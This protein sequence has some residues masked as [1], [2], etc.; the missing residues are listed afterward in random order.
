MTDWRLHLDLKDLWDED[1]GKEPQFIDWPLRGKQ[2][3]ERIRAASWF[4][5]FPDELGRI[6]KRFAG[7]KTQIGFDRA[8]TA[9]WDWADD[10]KCWVHTVL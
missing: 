10:H 9:L 6:A 5:L 8:C 4:S 3:S 1:A 7:A 2:V